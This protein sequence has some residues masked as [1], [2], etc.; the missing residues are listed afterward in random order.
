M[1]SHEL[2][3][4]PPGFWTGLRGMGVD[5]RDIVRKARLPLHLPMEPLE[6]TTAQYFA[7]WE[8]YSDLVGDVSAGIVKLT[9]A[10]ETAQYPPTVLA[11]YHA[12]N[13]RDALKRTVRYKQMCPPEHL[14]ISEEDEF[15]TIELE[16]Q[17]DGQP[18]PPMLVGI[19]LANLLELGR[20]GTGQ[21][22]T[23]ASVELSYS[24]N[25]AQALEAYFGCPIRVGADGNRMRLHR[26]DLDRPFVSYNAELLEILTPVLDRS[27][28]DKQQC[29]SVRE[30]VKWILKRSLTGGRLDIQAVAGELGM[31]GRTL[32][33]RLTDEGTSFKTLM[34]QARQEQAREYLADSSL[35]IKEVAFLLG[36]EDQNSF[37]RAFRQWEGDTPA[38]WRAEH[39][40][41]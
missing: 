15:C 21:A 32:Q 40:S 27:L 26:R 23:A 16:W 38:N 25:D 17:D 10:F 39:K 18:G 24:L 29:G 41:S 2:I 7:I 34:T 4:I 5:P 6:V 28:M 22:L 19:T 35:E 30:I 11:T 9:T 13:Y 14:R 31:S 33:R 8:A 36:Y 12:R 20:R 37:Y 1:T 3:K